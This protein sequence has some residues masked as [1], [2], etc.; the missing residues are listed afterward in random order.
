MIVGGHFFVVDVVVV[1]VHL[2]GGETPRQQGVEE[3]KQ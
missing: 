1:G 3:N 2:T